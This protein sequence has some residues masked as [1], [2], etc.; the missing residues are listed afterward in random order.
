MGNLVYAS[1]AKNSWLKYRS[2]WRAFAE[3]EAASETTFTWP[4]TNEVMRGFAIYCTVNKKLKPS[5]TQ[6][7]ISA[8]ACLHKIKGYGNYEYKDSLITSILRGASNLLMSSPSPPSNTRRVVTL[9]LLR[10]IGHKIASSG[11]CTG[12]KQTLW[13][14]CLTA[15]FGSARMGE[16]LSENEN[17]FDPTSTLKWS[18]VQFRPDGSILLFLSMPKSGAKEGEFIDLFPFP[19]SCC[20]V[21]ALT[22]HYRIQKAMGRGNPNDPVF[23]FPSGKFLTTSKLNSILRSLLSD[24]FDYKNDSI[25]C[26]SFRAGIPSTLARFPDLASAEDVKKWGRWSSSCHETYSRLRI[27]QKRT[28]FAKI[29]AALLRLPSIM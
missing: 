11:W 14:T 2:G 6:S 28:I 29:I 23:I 21:A 12:T 17:S 4:I 3:Y 25:S 8:V 26:H 20:P 10:I 9:P 7:Y 18:N 19:G 24:M 27:D 13:A 15:F 22:T 16:L 5:S 1:I